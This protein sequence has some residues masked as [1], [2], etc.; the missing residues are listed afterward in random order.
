MTYKVILTRDALEDLE[1]WKKHDKGVFD[2][3][4]ALLKSIVLDPTSGIG[5]PERLRYKNENM[6]SRRITREHRLVYLVEEEVIYVL[7]CRFHYK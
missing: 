5:K 1:F 2:K 3:I 7:E 4:G 6:W